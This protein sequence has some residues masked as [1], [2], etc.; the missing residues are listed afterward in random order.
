MEAGGRG[1]WGEAGEVVRML[2][3]APSAPNGRLDQNCPDSDPCL[4]RTM[5]EKERNTKGGKSS[6]D[7]RHSAAPILDMEKLGRSSGRNANPAKKNTQTKTNH[8]QQRGK[9]LMAQRKLGVPGSTV[10][11]DGLSRHATDLL[12]W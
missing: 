2:G 8:N 3:F 11:S 7:K 5:M 4:F 10:Q 6:N 9:E 1:R 12:S